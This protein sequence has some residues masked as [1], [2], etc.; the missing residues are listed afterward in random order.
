MDRGKEIQTGRNAESFAHM[1]LNCWISY[2]YLCADVITQNHKHTVFK[3]VAVSTELLLEQ[4]SYELLMQ[5]RVHHSQKCICN[6][7]DDVENLTAENLL[8]HCVWELRCVELD[9]QKVTIFVLYIYIHI[10]T[11][12]YTH[13]HTHTHTHIYIYIYIYNVCVCVCVCVCWLIVFLV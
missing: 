13:T 4:A 5:A 7:E 12:T 2:I 10:Y 6:G 11:H 3:V 1:P 9:N 8:Y